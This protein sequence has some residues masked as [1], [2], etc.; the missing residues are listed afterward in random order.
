MGRQSRRPRIMAFW[1]MSEE[2]LLHWR[3]DGWHGIQAW[4]T[5]RLG[6]ASLPPYASLNLS[7]SVNDLPAAVMVNRRRAIAAGV[8]LSVPTVVWARQVHGRDIA[9]VDG[10]Q[11]DAVADGL[12][13]RT[14]NVVLAM[15]F[16]DCVPIWI[17][18]DDQSMGG[19]VHAGW[20]GTVLDI[21]GA[22]VNAFEQ[23]GEDPKHLKAAIGPSIGP[24]CYEV[25][26]PV[27]EK[28]R[29]LEDGQQFLASTGPR[30]YQ[31]DL[32]GLNRWLLMRA[33]IPEDAIVG[34]GLCTG[35]HPDWFFSHR[36]EQARTGRMGGFLCLMP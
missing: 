33:G 35:C 26:E 19:L 16:A 27:A 30:H 6:G 22:A 2:G 32:W 5:G 10:T 1:K 28:V 4:F 17:V 3:L 36:R 24:C 9:W 8:P 23:A 15:A 18:S 7:R 14:P 21:A 25:D 31:L 20:R 12:L 34:A 13:T 29:R 11:P